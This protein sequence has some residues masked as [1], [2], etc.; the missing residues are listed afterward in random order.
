MSYII[1]KGKKYS[2]QDAKNISF[3]N[4]A[5]NLSST[6][7]ED[8][9]K[10][11]N[12]NLNNKIG[13][14]DFDNE[15]HKF[16]A[17]GMSWTA[18]ENCFLVGIISSNKDNCIVYVNGVIV[19]CIFTIN[20]ITNSSICVPVLKGQTVTTEPTSGTYVFSAYGLIN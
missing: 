5:T 17:R 9:I 13:F 10:E 19:G 18:T 15:L 6:N 4:T 8:V 11:Q 3:D 2:T 16:D 20:V 7:I 1:Y 12:S 14:I